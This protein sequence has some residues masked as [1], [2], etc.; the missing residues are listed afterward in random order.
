M[1]TVSTLA[2]NTGP[3]R[4]ADPRLLAA[5]E[6]ARRDK[7]TFLRRFVYTCD[8]HDKDNPIKPFPADRPH[9]EQ[10]VRL[11][12]NNRLLAVVK[13]RQMIMTWLF[14][15]IALHEVMTKRGRLVMLQSKR[16]E[17]AI[18]DAVSG[19][20]LLGRA[21][22]ILNQ[23]PCHNK[24][25]LR[26]TDRT[27]RIQFP[28]TNSTL[29][30]IPQGATIIRQRT[31]S[32]ILSDECGFQE[33]FADAYTAAM[34]CIRGGG[35]FVALSTAHPGFHNMLIEDRVSETA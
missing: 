30:A 5:W 21:K 34:P 19:D 11:W 2:M 17:D 31:A 8:Q 7:M 32:G 9:I 22:F 18:G 29:W 26:H 14:V 16:E 6:R 27:N 12:E 4:V 15:A 33:E 10:M 20:G 35:W 13:S 3:R 23:I 24:L 28:A 1:T 25:G